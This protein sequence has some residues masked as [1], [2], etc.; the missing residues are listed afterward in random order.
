MGK[1]G[2]EGEGGGGAGWKSVAEGRPES[3]P[4]LVAS[5]LPY[6]FGD[7]GA[8]SCVGRVS[9]S[10]CSVSDKVERGRS[11]LPF[12]V[13][14]LPSWI[15]IHLATGMRGGRPGLPEINSDF[16]KRSC[17]RAEKCTPPSGVEV[18]RARL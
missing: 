7:A 10:P 12:P 17:L 11:P 2:R 16:E 1:G 13:A 6:R 14:F 9:P 5:F 18:L 4:D 8:R 3:S 15:R